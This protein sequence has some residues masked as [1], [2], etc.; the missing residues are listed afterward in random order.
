VVGGE[1]V[2]CVLIFLG[3]HV[4]D[5]RHDEELP[6]FIGVDQLFVCSYLVDDGLQR[7]VGGGGVLAR[8]L[9]QHF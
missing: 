8:V 7:R 2:V 3:A 1:G 6:E 4:D 9:E 5:D